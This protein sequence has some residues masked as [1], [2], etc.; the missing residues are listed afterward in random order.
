MISRPSYIDSLEKP[1]AVFRFKYRSRG[2]LKDLFGDEVKDK[3]EL[4]ERVKATK[5]KV[6]REKE[7]LE[8]MGREELVERMVRLKLKGKEREKGTDREEKREGSRSTESV[9]R[10]RMERWV[11][12]QSL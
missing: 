12:G 8:G 7:K 10:G 5:A 11:E 3:R 4:V 6:Q 2:V 9:A 1:Y